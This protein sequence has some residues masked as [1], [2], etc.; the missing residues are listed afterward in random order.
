MG[1]I[2]YNCFILTSVLIGKTFIGGLLARMIRNNTDASILCVC[3][4][5][6]ALDQFLEYML[7]AGED[8]LV[9]IGGRSKSS[10]L[11]RYQLRDLARHKSSMLS[12]GDTGR[13]IKQIDAQL[14]AMRK[15]IDELVE[16]IKAPINW[17][18]PHGGVCRY[19]QDE[20]VE[21]FHYLN[22]GEITSIDGFTVVGSDGRRLREDTLWNQWITGG[23]FPAWLLPHFPFATS[24]RKFKTFW[25]Q[26]YSDRI[27]LVSKWKQDLSSE[28][29]SLLRSAIERYRSLTKERRAAEHHQDLGILKDA[30]VIGATTTGACQY[31][32]ILREKNVEV[33]VV[34]EAGEV[35]EAHVLST[36]QME[37]K[38]LILIGDH[39]QLRPKVEDFNLTAVSGS[40]FD[41]DCSL[42]ERL[43]LADQQSVCLGVQHRMRPEISFFVRQQTY[44]SLQDHASVRSFPNV[45]GVAHN[46]VFIN[47]SIPEDGL[48]KGMDDFSAQTTKSNAHEAGLCTEILRYLLLQGYAPNRVVLLTPYLGQVKK[49]LQMVQRTMNDVKASVSEKDQRDLE[50]LDHDEDELHSYVSQTANGHTKRQVRVSSIDN[51]QGEEA[52]IVVISLVRSNPRGNIGFMKEEQRVNVLMSRAK[53]GLYIVGNAA[54]LRQSRQGR[55]IWSPI[56]DTLANRNQLLKGLPTTCQLHPDDPPIVLTCK[57]DFREQRP[58]GGCS[59]PCNYRMACGHAC[60]MACHPFDREHTE[61]QRQCLERCMRVPPGCPMDH[62]CPKLCKDECGPCMSNVGPIQLSCGHSMANVYCH[63]ARDS[64]NIEKLSR[65]CLVHVP[66]TFDPCGHSGMTTCANSKKEK[67]LCPAECGVRCPSCGHPCA[68]LC[69]ECDSNHDCGRKCERMMFCG[70]VCERPCHGDSPCPPCRKR[71]PVQCAHSICPKKCHS[72]VCLQSYNFH[73]VLI[74]VRIN[75]SPVRSMCRKM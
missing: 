8:R 38:H 56:L 67:P 43:I 47:H 21:C 34:E 3:Y 24:C 2:Q 5:N 65:R 44:P 73:S 70:H 33:V 31:K 74:F 59:R 11:S 26:P 7:D 20:D 48:G 9:R 50:L 10:R 12:S 22:V 55:H 51:F 16:N 63:E 19:L 53:I 4:T 58:N 75:P 35:L 66:F 25:S 36:L 28:D 42:F 37:T 68:K 40:G 14:H 32:D 23:S 62:P 61:A 52:D 17:K 49:L 72:P 13:R 57:Q 29:T 18:T 54:T 69:S 60:R 64:K 41:L 1:R 15:E 27:A 71:C 45:R 46:V 30:R 6:H 39:K